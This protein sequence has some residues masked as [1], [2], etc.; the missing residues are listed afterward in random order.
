MKLS[1]YKWWSVAIVLPL[2]TI[3]LSFATSTLAEPIDRTS[4]ATK[5]RIP[6]FTDLNLDVPRSSNISIDRDAD[7]IKPKRISANYS[8]SMRREAGSKTKSISIPKTASALSISPSIS[9]TGEQLDRSRIISRRKLLVAIDPQ[10]SIE[11]DRRD[12][13][14]LRN[15]NNQ[16]IA[17]ISPPPLS[18]NYLR[19]V[20]D[21]SKGNNN[22]GNPIYT[23][24][25]YV[26][27]KLYQSFDAVSGIATSQRF[28]RNIG[29]NHAPLPDGFYSV[30]DRIVPGV[31]PEVDRTFISIRPQFTTN[32]SDL[33]IH[34][35]PSFNKRNGY[36][37]TSGCIG[38]TTPVDRDAIN[39]F[40]I[41]YH[42]RNLFV[43]ILSKDDP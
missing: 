41:K 8:T 16:K 13:R 15:I 38:L 23:L 30:S 21:P 3:D 7:K 28:D 26:N 24:E 22:L 5:D 33:G 12:L 17:A 37:G 31:V 39:Q 29:N 18:G 10:V 40:T 36:D 2:F 9:T 32:R 19:L 14:K 34:L 35:D 27:G 43:K 20:R 4:T 42:P 6:S 1:T 25:A 11:D